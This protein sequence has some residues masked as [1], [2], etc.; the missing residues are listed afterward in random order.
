MSVEEHTIE[1]AGSPVFFRTAATPL[2]PPLFLHGIPTSSADWREVQERTGGLAPDLLGFG[3]SGKGGQLEMTPGAMAGFLKQLLDHQG[4]PR[5]GLVASGWSALPA[6]LFVAR[7]PTQVKRIALLNPLH[8]D[9][10]QDWPRAARLLRRQ[11]LGELIMGSVNERLLARF[12]RRGAGSPETWSDERVADVWQGFDQGTQRSILR[13]LRATDREALTEASRALETL[14]VPLLTVWGERDPWLSAPGAGG[15]GE[16]VR[17]SAAGH[18]PW[19]DCP[20]AAE[21]LVAFLKAT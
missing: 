9:P 17:F 21:R 14:A 2:V 8:P 4:I 18:W 12:L 6:L 5:V 19:L 1:L 10:D 20:D 3:A 16:L 13:L 15:P 7:H 11:V